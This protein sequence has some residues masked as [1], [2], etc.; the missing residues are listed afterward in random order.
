MALYTILFGS[1]GSIPKGADDF[2]LPYLIFEIT[3][4]HDNPLHAG[5]AS[6]GINCG[7]G[8]MA[9]WQ[10]SHARSF[11]ATCRKIARPGWPNLILFYWLLSFVTMNSNPHQ[12]H[13][14]TLFAG[15]AS[16]YQ[17]QILNSFAWTRCLQL[18]NL[19]I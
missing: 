14:H 2:Y 11:L 13:P 9:P 17:S 7:L 15:L 10:N 3:R 16:F 18:I 5:F 19:P 4:S 6:R 8:T 1:L 12:F